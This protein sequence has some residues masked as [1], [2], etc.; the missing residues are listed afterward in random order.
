MEQPLFRAPFGTEVTSFLLRSQQSGPG[1]SDRDRQAGGLKN[2]R[3]YNWHFF[4][5]LFKPIS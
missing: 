5:Q 4:L 3:E 1:G 2:V